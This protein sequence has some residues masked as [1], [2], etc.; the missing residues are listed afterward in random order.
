[1]PPPLSKVLVIRL[2]SIGDIVLTSPFLRV[3]KARYPE[4]EL[5]FVV[6][7]EYADLVRWNP[8]IDKLITV[9]VAHGRKALETLNLALGA[10]G[11]DAV[12]DL[13]HHLRTRIIRNGVS[14][15]I[16]HVDKRALRRLLLVST[17]LNW[18]GAV[19][20]VPERYI[21][22]AS[23][24]GVA[25]DERGCELF[26]PDELREDTLVR[27][28][29]RGWD[30]QTR[31]IGLCPGSRH[32]TKRWPLAKY[33]RLTTLLLERGFAV[34]VLGS[35][36]DA[37]AGQALQA[38]DPSRVFSFCGTTTLIET[39]ALL[40]RCA[41]VAANDSG[42]MHMAT[43]V[44]R[45]VTAIFGSTVREFGFYPYNS[46]ASVIEVAGLSCRPCTFIG[47]RSCPKGHFRCMENISVERVLEAVMEM[48]E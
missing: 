1:M 34:A 48:A 36:E 30:A 46:R 32:F 12:F 23:R 35:A 28:C 7:K 8:N 4:T 5:H 42:L 44:R 26:Y 40:E 19:M 37:E 9:D 39:A 24:Y 45:P 41:V 17:H 22:T 18:Y 33:L 43:A 31:I 14:R 29:A 21:E 27:L 47:R 10:E 20:P 13:H 6:R 15:N 38:V 2:S 3:F 11:Y 16:H 25:P